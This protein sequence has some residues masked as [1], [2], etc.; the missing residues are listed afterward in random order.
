MQDTGI[1]IVLRM[2]WDCNSDEFIFSFAKIV[3][4]AAMLEPTKRNILSILASL[5]DPLGVVSPIAVDLKVLLQEL[6]VNKGS[7]DEKLTGEWLRRWECWVSELKRVKEMRL[8]RCVYGDN[9]DS[10]KNSL[11]GFADA[12]SKAY[13]AVIYFVSEFRGSINGT[14]L[15]SKTR[16]AP[17]SAQTI[18]SLELMAA[19]TLACL[20]DTVKN[21]LANEVEIDEIRLWPGKTVLCWIENKKEWKTFVRHRVNEILKLTRKSEWGYCRSEENPADIGSRGLG[22]DSL[23][24]ADLWW[25]G[26]RWLSGPQ[27]EWPSNPEETETQES[28]LESKKGVVMM[29][30]AKEQPSAENPIDVQKYSKVNKLYRV[31]AYIRRFISNINARRRGGSK[32]ERRAEYRGNCWS[33]KSLDLGNAGSFETTGELCFTQ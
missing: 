23:R 16:V 30:N 28:T 29:L 11:I 24:K 7:W 21:A 6:C 14:F 19:R 9:K 18:P 32:I 22:A 1:E 13:C 25:N 10:A 20:M 26:P 8:P 3:E 31:T 5:Y 17:L 2:K 33:R 4:Q 15:T 27:E 12:S